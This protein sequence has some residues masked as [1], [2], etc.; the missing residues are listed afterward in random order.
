MFTMASI[1][2]RFRKQESGVVA[3]L[4]GIAIIPIMLLVGAAVDYSRL[5]AAHT[6]AQ[7]AADAAALAAAASRIETESAMSS[8]ATNY[9]KANTTGTNADASRITTFRYDTTK[10]EVTLIA[11]GTIN[12][13]FMQLAGYSQLSYRVTAN[14]IRALNGSTE[15]VLVLDNTWSMA[16][17]KLAALKESAEE[18]V[19]TLWRDPSV[20][21]KIGVVPYADYVNVGTGNR[22]ASWVSVPADYDVTSQRTCVTKTTRSVCTRGAAKTCTRTVDGSVETYDCT[23]QTCTDQTVAPY[24][25]CSGGG[26]TRYRW[27]GCVGSRNT[28]TLRLTDAQPSTPYPGYLATSQNCLN[29]IIP[30]S[31]SP[32]TVTTAIR[33][34]VV[35]VGNYKPSTYIPTGLIWGVNVLS[36]TA[37]FSEGRAYDA[38]NRRP[39]KVMVLMT[40]GA[41]TLQ[42]RASD[43]RHV[44][45]SGNA[46][47]QATQLAQT[48]TDM[49][50]ICTYA[51]S[52]QI[53]I[54][55]I[56]FDIT[57]TTARTAMRNCA[58]SAAH[59]FDA[60]DRTSLQDAFKN[61]AQSLQNV[62]LTR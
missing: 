56:A 52:Q 55:T 15:L 36:P 6:A 4:F 11:E 39:R 20:D 26:T 23:P 37:P 51:K 42:Y 54:Y 48:Y 2:H 31:T 57:D 59:A 3:I 24:E 53:E 34:M 14:S 10:R 13:A 7:A 38:A 49:N 29:P 47:N 61:I 58:S 30:L 21:V 43:G 16:G 19:T 1:L 40:D 17:T 5:S 41:N 50:A 18:L 27:Y 25:S 62:R 32:S 44:A 22:N 9:M 60:T 35:N 28:G 8:I 12:P 46:A 33:G 45:F